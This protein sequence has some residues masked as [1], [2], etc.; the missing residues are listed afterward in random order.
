MSMT[1]IFHSNSN[2]HAGYSDYAKIITNIKYIYIY[3]SETFIHSSEVY[4]CLIL[5]I[6][7]LRIKN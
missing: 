4:N 7:Y 5:L 1:N 6:I 3:I 2:K